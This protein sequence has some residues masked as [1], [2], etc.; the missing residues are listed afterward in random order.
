MRRRIVV[1]GAAAAAG[2]GLAYALE[3]TAVR[4][5]KADPEA[6]TAAGRAMP[7]DIRHHFLPVDDGGR[8]HVI[9]RGSGPPLVLVHGVTLGVGIWVPQFQQLARSHRVI[10]VGQR[11]HGQSL[12]GDDGYSIERLA[13]DL[14]SVLE[15]LAVERAVI[16]GHSM[17]GMVLQRLAVSDPAALARHAAGLVLLAT[18]PGGFAPGGFVGG[19]VGWLTTALAA[20]GLGYAERRGQGLVPQHD[21]GAWATRL[22]FGTSPQAVDVELSRSMLAAMSPSAMHG[23]LVPLLTFDVRSELDRIELP[24]RIVVGTRD[25]LTPLRMARIMAELIPRAELVVYPGCGHMVMLERDDEFD[26]LLSRFSGELVAPGA[27]PASR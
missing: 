27:A 6:L 25:V 20:Q 23:L 2:A 19:A 9:E 4:R 5:W 1:A 7:G 24:T 21:L 14:R 17:G 3:K 16:V 8:L 13:E 15:Q 12:G 22:T 18:T 26:E 11:G 10:A